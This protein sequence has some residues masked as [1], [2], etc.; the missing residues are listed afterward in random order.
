LEIQEI[1][2]ELKNEIEGIDRAIAALEG[3]DPSPVATKG[4]RPGRPSTSA[5]MQAAPAGKRTG[6]AL[7]AEGRRRLSESMKKQ[8]AERRKK[9]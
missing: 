8:W 9:A 7:T 5:K 3:M 6:R 2:A 4:R 1:I